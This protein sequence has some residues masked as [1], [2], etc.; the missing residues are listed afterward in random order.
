VHDEITGTVRA[1]GLGNIAG[2]R[3]RHGAG[4]SQSFA[5]VDKEA[6]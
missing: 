6:L 1:Q 2:V 3:A 5:K 4:D